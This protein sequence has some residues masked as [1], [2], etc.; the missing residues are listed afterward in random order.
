MIEMRI[1]ITSSPWKSE[2]LEA[3]SYV[4]ESRA[5]AC[6]IALDPCDHFAPV[7]QLV[8]VETD[9]GFRVAAGRRGVIEV[10]AGYRIV[11]TSDG[12][13]GEATLA[14]VEKGAA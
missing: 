2:P 7:A 13:D 9:R 14:R 5:V 4:F 6:W 8:N 1:P 11:V 3:G 10:F 12:E